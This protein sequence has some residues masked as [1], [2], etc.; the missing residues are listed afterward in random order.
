[1]ATVE[2]EGT[3]CFYDV[4]RD[5]SGEEDYVA[6]IPIAEKPPES[7]DSFPVLYKRIKYWPS[8]DDYDLV[9]IINNSFFDLDEC[10][11]RVIQG[12]LVETGKVCTNVRVTLNLS[13]ENFS[14]ISFV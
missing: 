12:V 9:V 11:R 8:E 3:L 6:I 13:P 1:M 4:P 2:V 7:F 14:K 10:R 5:V